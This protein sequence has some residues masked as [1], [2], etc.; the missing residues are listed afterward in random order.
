MKH[1][2]MV[3]QKDVDAIAQRGKDRVKEFKQITYKTAKESEARV[4]A[5]AKKVLGK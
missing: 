5:F 1:Y 2:H 4:N 3:G